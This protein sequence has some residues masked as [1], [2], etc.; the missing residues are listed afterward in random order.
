[1]NLAPYSFFTVAS[2]NPPVLSVTHIT[3]RDRLVKDTLINLQETGEC[4]VNIVSAEQV[5][6]MNATCADYPHDTSEFLVAEVEQVLSVSVSPPGVKESKVRYE[7]RLKEVF[8]ISDLPSGGKL[9][10]LDVIGINIDDKIFINRS[11]DPKFLDALG[12]MGGDYYS[13]TR[14]LFEL[15]RPIL[16]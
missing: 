10:L 9:M 2:C 15:A 16:K 12:K 14:E 3:P 11:I 1:V 5:D 6:K 8:P 7:C 13:Y 4:V